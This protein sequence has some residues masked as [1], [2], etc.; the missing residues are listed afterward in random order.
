MSGRP[1]FNE[2]RLS[3]NKFHQ[4]PE[5]RHSATMGNPNDATIDI[6]LAA[7][8]SGVQKNNPYEPPT[9]APSPNMTEKGDYHSNA[10]SRR[11]TR[12]VTAGSIEESEEGTLTRM[13]K[14][15]KAILNFS[16]VTRYMI[17]VSPVALIIALP[18][19][20]GATIEPNAR[21]GGVKI[22]WFFTWVEVVWLALWVSKI[23]AHFLPYIFQFLCGIVSSGTRKYALILQSLEIPV[24]LVGW[25][26]VSV[27]TFLPVRI[28]MCV[29]SEACC[30]SD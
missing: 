10:A 16:V 6:P 2:K 4:L 3:G 9:S 12:T 13:G 28:S 20:I 29:S 25:C 23:F 22:S 30:G 8:A 11:R 5:D 27:V 15:Y 19:I 7:V 17:Y 18:I 21:I 24:S 14:F 1:G 26:V